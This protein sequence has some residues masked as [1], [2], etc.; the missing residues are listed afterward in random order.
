MAVT[1]GEVCAE[2]HNYFV[3]GAKDIYSE[4]FTISGGI[5]TPSNFLLDGQYFRIERSVLNDGVYQYTGDGIESLKDETFVGYVWAMR[6]PADFLALV[7]KIS[8]WDN[9]YG[10]VNTA[11]MSPYQSES[12][13]GQYSYTKASGGS[14]NRGG[15]S[16]QSRF[17]SQLERYRKVHER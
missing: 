7:Q 10:G 12:Y 1:V 16:W 8:E 13:A 6:I 11:N 15:E 5:I 17:G 9:K 2:V 3:N 4:N 14:S